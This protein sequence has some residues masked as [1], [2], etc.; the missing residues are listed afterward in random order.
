M[1]I[2]LSKCL[3]VIGIVLVVVSFSGIYNWLVGKE[4]DC[5]Y[6][7]DIFLQMRFCE[8]VWTGKEEP[9]KYKSLSIYAVLFAV[10]IYLIKTG[11]NKEKANN[12]GGKFK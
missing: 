1:R 2:S 9:I 11:W 7:T 10:G 12:S 3:N 8:E 6:T 5:Y 4:P